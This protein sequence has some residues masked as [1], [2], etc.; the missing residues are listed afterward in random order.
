MGAV[1]TTAR[2]RRLFTVRQ[3]VS[4][5]LLTVAFVGLVAAFMMHD[6]TPSAALRPQAVR[7]VSPQPGSLQLR[8]AEIFVVLDPTY[9][10]SLDV[11]GTPIPDDQ[12]K[13]LRGVNRISF[14]PGEGKEITKLPPGPT[15]VVVTYDLAV[16]GGHPGSYR[17]CFTVS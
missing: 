6:D 5:A 17:W 11:N 7:F 9:S 1:S 13:V 15:C 14:T 4:A 10:G 2:P 16:G 3:V 8:Q 12:L